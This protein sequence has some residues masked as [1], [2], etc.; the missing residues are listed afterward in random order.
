MKIGI[1]TLPLHIN[2]GG[3]MQ[4]Y[5]LQTRLERM[6]HDVIV[7]QKDVHPNYSLPFWKYPLAYGKRMLKKIL[8]DKREPLNKEKINKREFPIIQQHLNTFI[9][10]HIHTVM[11]ENVA[12]INLSTIDCIV[13]GSD[14]IWRPIHVKNLLKTRIQDAYLS[15]TKDWDGLRVA[16]ATSFGVENWEYTKK[17]TEDCRKL[18]RLF[19]AVSV[20]ELSAV[21]LC[22]KHL[23]INA[24]QVLDPT[25]LLKEDDYRY[26]IEKEN[27]SSQ[28]E[29]LFSYILDDTPE[30]R[31]FVKQCAKKINKKIHNITINPIDK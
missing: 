20:R 27:D 18:V 3:I 23:G 9:N 22:Y 5:A 12:N 1:L 8:V 26:L 16:Y 7:F 19:N 31:L 10:G 28:K 17:E 4:V 21:G 30:K 25:L 6:G 11:Y 29:T 2:Y 15:F 14:Q 24:V 13:V